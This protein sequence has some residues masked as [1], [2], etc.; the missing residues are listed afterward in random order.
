VDRAERR[1]NF[2]RAFRVRYGRH[3]QI[4]YPHS[5]RKVPEFIEWLEEEVSTAANSSEKPSNE[6]F[7]ESRLPEQIGIAYRAMYAHGMHL[8][9]RSA[10]EEKVTFD[11]GVA[12]AV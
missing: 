6:E 3:A 4:H 9:V 2:K 8:R 7:E 11:S 10:E 12:S 5:L 1:G